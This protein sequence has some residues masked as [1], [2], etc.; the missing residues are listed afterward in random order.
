MTQRLSA[1]LVV[2]WFREGLGRPVSGSYGEMSVGL[3]LA[4][5]TFGLERCHAIRHQQPN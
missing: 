1:G 5:E 4:Q 3:M 2:R